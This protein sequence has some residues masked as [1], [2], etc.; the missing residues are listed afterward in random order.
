MRRSRHVHFPGRF[1]G[2]LALL[3]RLD[4]QE[5]ANVTIGLGR[6]AL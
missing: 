1:T 5:A 3:A 2:I 6:R 4:F